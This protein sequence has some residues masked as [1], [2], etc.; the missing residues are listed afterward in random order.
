MLREN[1]RKWLA[2]TGLVSFL[3]WTAPAMADSIRVDDPWARSSIGIERPGVA[4]MTIHNDGNQSDWLRSVTTP[5]AK[6]AEIHETVREDEVLIMQVVE[7][8]KIPPNA[9]VNLAP[10][11][12]H[13]MLMSLQK[14]L[15]EG[16]NFPLTL[17]FAQ[18]GKLTVSVAISDV[19]ANEAP[20][21]SH[22]HHGQHHDHEHH[23]DY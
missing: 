18:A 13:V 6:R 3:V 9:T 20:V 2:L 19:A 17:H 23:H 22:D 11:G 1:L 7:S 12:L 8:V 10:G 15:V 16:E 21:V 4:Y 5:L 14:I